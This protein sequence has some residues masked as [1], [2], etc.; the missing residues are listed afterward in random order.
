M[1]YEEEIENMIFCWIAM[2]PEE[3]QREINCV[4]DIDICL[5]EEAEQEIKDEIWNQ[6][7]NNINYKAI[8]ERVKIHLLDKIETQS[9]SEEE[10]SLESDS[11]SESSSGSD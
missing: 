9:M 2:L 3:E 11:E 10:E 5:N 8:L 7:K 1:D 4:N 6:L